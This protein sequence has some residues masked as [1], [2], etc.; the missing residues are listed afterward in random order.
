MEAAAQTAPSC[1]GGSGERDLPVSRSQV[2]D[3]TQAY[4]KDVKSG[5]DAQILTFQ[6]K[7]WSSDCSSKSSRFGWQ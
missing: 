7:S 3:L 4:G 6:G 2:S 1:R 5:A